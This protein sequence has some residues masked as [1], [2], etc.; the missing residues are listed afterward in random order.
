MSLPGH[1]LYQLDYPTQ[2]E[3]VRFRRGNNSNAIKKLDW[4]RASGQLIP[5]G[6]SLFR[7]QA[8]PTDLVTFSALKLG[9]TFGRHEAALLGWA[10]PLLDDRLLSGHEATLLGW[11]TPP[12]AVNMVQAD[13]A[14]KMKVRCHM[15]Q[16]LSGWT[17]FDQGASRRWT[18]WT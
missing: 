9:L 4:S 15:P 1:P 16:K 11:A 2:P 13:R 5:P 17:L 14:N 6:N 12:P 10:M 7:P 8:R 3:L 18:P